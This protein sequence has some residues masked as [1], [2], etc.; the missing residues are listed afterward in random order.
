ME[1]MT[2][3][4]LELIWWI[5][6]MGSSQWLEMDV[7]DQVQPLPICV[8]VGFIARESDESITVV[9][10]GQTRKKDT[11]FHMFLGEIT[12]PKVAVLARKYLGYSPGKSP[13]DGMVR[14]G[15]RKRR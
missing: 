9:Q 7:L 13:G 2:K 8:S 11:E 4:P 3:F 6:S 1:M 10:T 15:I 14:R 5:D 12:I